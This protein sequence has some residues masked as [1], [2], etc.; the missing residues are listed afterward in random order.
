VLESIKIH[1]LKTKHAPKHLIESCFSFFQPY[2]SIKMELICISPF[3]LTDDFE[4]DDCFTVLEKTRVSN[5]IDPM[6]F[7]ILLTDRRNSKNW[8][9]GFDD[10][11]NVRNIFIQ[12]SDWDNY[13]YSQATH[14]VIYEIIATTLQS[15]L[16]KE[17]GY[18][19]AHENP[20]A[21]LNDFCGW[22]PDIQFKIKS[23]DICKTCLEKLEDLVSERILIEAIDAL[24]KVREKVIMSSKYFDPP[25]FESLYFSHIAITKRKITSNNDPLRKTLFAIDHFD[26]L[27]KTHI[28]FTLILNH[29]FADIEQFLLENELI[30]KPS[31]GRWV[32]ALQALHKDSKQNK[33]SSRLNSLTKKILSICEKKKIVQLRNER[34]GHGYINCSDINYKHD[35]TLL[36]DILNQLEDIIINAIGHYNLVRGIS[37]SKQSTNQYKISF[38]ILQGS[39]MLLEEKTS[40]LN[41]NPDF[42]DGNLY[43]VS[44]DWKEWRSLHP[45]IL[46]NTCPKCNYNRLLVKDGGQYLD[47]LEGHLVEIKEPL[48]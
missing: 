42:V 43:L 30:Q 46:F 3:D 47:I 24:N 32:G 40:I 4:W 20:I 16:I 27:I 36:N 34:R 18:G 1:L 26:L 37:C 44:K 29:E 25:S 11:N 21:C 22:K 31:L 41:F 45:Y 2:V 28:Y 10:I 15:F 13:I 9:A 5:N 14:L 38:N 6:D 48:N 33:S 23:A 39:N 17:N 12:T 35:F 7:V 8:F 19:F